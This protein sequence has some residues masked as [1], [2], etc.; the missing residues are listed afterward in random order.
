MFRRF[1][2]IV[3][4]AGANSNDPTLDTFT[5]TQSNTYILAGYRVLALQMQI[6]VHQVIRFLYSF[7]SIPKLLSTSDVVTFHR[8]AGST[9]ASSGGLYAAGI[10]N[11][12]NPL[13]V[14]NTAF[15][16]S[17]SVTPTTNADFIVVITDSASSSKSEWLELSPGLLTNVG[18][19]A[20]IWAPGTG[21]LTYTSPD[22][23]TE[24]VII[25]GFKHQ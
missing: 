25:A 9:F 22:A 24:S 19:V 1:S 20:T 7:L 10:L 13:D 4:F 2:F 12:G 8:S 3:A 16:T 17:A 15:T 23:G 5:D 6:L 14:I 21:Q 18:T 11:T